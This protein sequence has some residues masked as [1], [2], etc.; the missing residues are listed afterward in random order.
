MAA[1]RSTGGMVMTQPFAYAL[2]WVPKTRL[3][4]TTLTRAHDLARAQ[5]HT[6]VSLEHLLLALIEDPD[7]AAVLLAC[8]VDLLKLNAAVAR[9]VQQHSVSEAAMPVADPVTMAT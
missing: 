5:G 1:A 4:A 2:T 3:L 8:S 9:H 7:A 6:A